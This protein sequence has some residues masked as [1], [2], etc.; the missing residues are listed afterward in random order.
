MPGEYRNI[1][2]TAR[3]SAGLTQE[4][5]AELLDISVESI[6]AYETGVRLPPNRV[7]ETMVEVYGLQ[8]LA[9]QHLKET[10]ALARQVI[11][12]L[13]ERSLLE[14]AVR[15]YTRL[16]RFAA[17]GSVDRLLEIA[18]DG[19]IDPEEQADF[20]AILADIQEIVRSGLELSVYCGEKGDYYA[21]S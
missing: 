8:P 14:V 3:L 4:A 9:Y 7:V 5:A 2:K 15:I 12:A 13:E 20:Q 11:P 6:R 19:R 10:N 1:Y 21:E 16:R 17:A 18:E